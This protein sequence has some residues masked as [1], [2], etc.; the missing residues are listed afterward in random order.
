MRVSSKCQYALRALFAIARRGE[1]GL[2]RVMEIA[3]EQDIP[4]RYLENIVNQ[5]RKGGFV[6]SRRGKEG[7]FSLSRPARDI[8]LGDVIRFIEGPIHPTGCN[9][10][11]PGQACRF[12]G[13]CVFIRHWNEAEKA[14]E[15]VYDNTTIQDLV[16]E[17][18]RFLQDQ[19][20]DYCI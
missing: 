18:R 13:R 10:E 1:P 16:E 2:S 14:L 8:R 7:G 4:P 15:S 20:L 17:D 5:L 11:K 6:H 3:E 19:A 12:K 9:G